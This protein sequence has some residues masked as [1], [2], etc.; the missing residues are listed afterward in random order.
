MMCTFQII[1]VYQLFSVHLNAPPSLVLLAG[2]KPNPE[3]L[4]FKKASFE[5]NDGKQI[6]LDGELMITALQYGPTQG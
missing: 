1:N 4:P 3:L 2:G 5:L 6:K